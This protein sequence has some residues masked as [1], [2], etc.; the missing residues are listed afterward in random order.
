MITDGS[1]NVYITGTNE[2]IRKRGHHDKK[3]IIP[4][5]PC[6][7]AVIIIHRKTGSTLPNSITRDASG[8]IYVTGCSFINGNGYRAVTIKYNSSG[9][10]QWVALF[11]PAEFFGSEGF[12]VTTDAAVKCLRGG[13][14]RSPAQDM[15]MIIVH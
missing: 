5:V 3:N 15:K 7:G 12:A 1:G 9:T 8:N 14:F 10:Q 11:N 2:R 13:A 6:N 4:Q